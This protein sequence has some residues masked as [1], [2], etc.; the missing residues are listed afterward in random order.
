MGQAG[1]RLAGAM[2]LCVLSLL[3]TMAMATPRELE[4]GWEY[5]WGDSPFLPDG[6]PAWTLPSNDDTWR[7]IGFPSNPPNREGRDH[8]WFRV[9]LPAGEWVDPVLYVYSIDLIAEA[10]L[11]GKRI[12][13]H[14]TF[15]AD[16]EGR[17]AGWPWH[18]IDLPEDTAGRWL[19]FRVYSDYT[20][21][22]LWGEIKL[23]ERAD[24]FGYILRHSAAALIVGPL[25]L[26]LALL[27]GSFA[28]I[29]TE[30]RSFAAIALFG[31]ASG[32]MIL[33]ESQASQ[34]LLD[35]PL[36]WDY[37]AAGGYFTLPI[38][39]GLLLEHWFADTRPRLIRCIWQGHL[40]YLVAAL[41]S[42]GLGWIDLATT[43][44][45]FDVLLIISLVVLLSAITPQL[46]RLDG[47]QHAIL[48]TF[49]VFG[50]LLLAD[51]A[52]AHGLLPWGRVPVS[53]GALAFTL[54]VAMISLL[55]YA[56][57]QRELKSLNQRL[58]TE[59]AARTHQ[60]QCL[61]ERLETYSY[62]DP[63]TG[64]HNRRYFDELL[65]HEAHQAQR[66]GAP[67]A[68][69]MIDI[70]H[71][72]QVNDRHGHEAGDQVLAGVAATLSEHFH[73]ADVVCRLGGEEFVVLLPGADADAA[74]ERL[75]A[76]MARLA[77]RVYWH[78]GRMLGPVTISC[79][80]AS[81]PTHATNPMALAR[82]ADRALYV[83]KEGGRAR[84][85]VYA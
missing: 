63:L 73:D 70:D 81:F 57:T 75:E 2:L 58:E 77:G 48:A 11:D 30:R 55:D 83:A 4:S 45:V 56:R 41:G 8:A 80:I 9:T 49:A 66:L 7:S 53:A 12:Y 3:A 64:L 69:A 29:Q 37:L 78:G 17:F 68:L 26:L 79:G 65:H 13:R 15:D 28:V 39:L 33:A 32:S 31:L 18:M 71:F 34:L 74:Q 35:A 76:L 52:V 20:D 50:A 44:P 5:R 22:G 67:L 6:T 82:L 38:A 47:R 60:L 72:K 54:A 25:C 40:G 61:V 16:G 21:I 36:L 46:R 59:V 51:M 27:A 23:M 10:Y 43:F 14:G 85:T 62:T 42:A 19:Y 84:V 1:K 24:L